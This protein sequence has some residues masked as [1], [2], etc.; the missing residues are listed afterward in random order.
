[1]A[2]HEEHQHSHDHHRHHHSSGTC[3]SN[4]ESSFED[5]WLNKLDDPAGERD[6][7]DVERGPPNFERVVLLI[8]GLQCGCCEGGITR[9]I[10]RISAIRNHQ[11]NV[12]LARLEFELDTNR[13]SVADVIVKLG[14]N[15]GY[16]FEEHSAPLGQ[17][18]ELLVTDTSKLELASMPFGVT[19]IE[20][21]EKQP[22]CLSSGTSAEKLVRIQ[23]DALQVGARDIFEYYQQVL[24]GLRLAP[25]VSHP[26]LTMGA[27]QTRHA[28]FWFLPALA[29][30]IPVVVLAWAPI[31]HGRTVYAHASLA[32][33]TLVQ[34]IA[35]KQFLP[36][37][38]RSLWYARVFE[39][40]FLIALS[41]G[42]AYTF[43]LIAYAFQVKGKPL[44]NTGSFFETSTML[45][46]LILLGR[47]I[48]E[49]ARYRAAKS[50]SFRFV[51]MPS[52]G[53]LPI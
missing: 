53:M 5:V 31:D 32:L 6:S 21:T 44:E 25:P 4:T 46:T 30:T 40:D 9:T 45:V 1:M 16:T 51:F 19:Q 17:V 15:T 49:F 43:S 7:S 27:K 12:V 24:G 33:A 20:S 22:G 10:T 34:A 36:N 42:I 28:L 47:V 13:M 41:S 48:N 39:M 35:F 23:Y 14:A 52:Y 37:A 50:V 2:V 3:C 38:L 11:V 26:S 8:D 29:L 18:L